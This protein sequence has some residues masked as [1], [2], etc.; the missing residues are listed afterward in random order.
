MESFLYLCLFTLVVS[1]YTIPAE[2]EYI[3]IILMVN[4][5]YD[6]ILSISRNSVRTLDMLPKQC[7]FVYFCSSF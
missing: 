3:L 4:F 1:T 6:S 2:S 5:F 7:G